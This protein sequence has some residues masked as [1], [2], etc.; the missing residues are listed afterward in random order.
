VS[1]GNLVLHEIGG[2]VFLVSRVERGV[3]V[4][5]VAKI[6]IDA[7]ALPSYEAHKSCGD[8][9]PKPQTVAILHPHTSG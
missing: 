9:A 7:R 1:L 2:V 8:G 6:A 5:R 3:A 4:I